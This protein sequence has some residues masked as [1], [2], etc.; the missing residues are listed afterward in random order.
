MAGW[1]TWSAP[2]WYPHPLGGA[3]DETTYGRRVIPFFAYPAAVRKITYTTNAMES[4]HMRLRKII[5]DWKISP[6]T[7]KEA[8]NQFAIIVGERFTAALH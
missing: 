5:K 7:W 1:K 4:L 6:R 2:C 3:C 8:S